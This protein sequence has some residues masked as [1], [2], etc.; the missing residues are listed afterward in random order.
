MCTKESR[1]LRIDAV[2]IERFSDLVRCL[3]PAFSLNNKLF[4]KFS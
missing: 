3:L 2:K 4:I 1:F